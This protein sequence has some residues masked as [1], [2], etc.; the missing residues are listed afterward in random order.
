MIRLKAVV[1]D[2][3]SGHWEMLT[4]EVYTDNKTTSKINRQQKD[5]QLVE[6]LKTKANKRL[7]DDLRTWFE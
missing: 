4:P 1:M 6:M 7:I 2:V 5:Q 3:A